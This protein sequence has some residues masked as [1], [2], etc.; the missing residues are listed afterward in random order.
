MA[1]LRNKNL[2]SPDSIRQRIKSSWD[3]T[4]LAPVGD[5]LIRLVDSTKGTDGTWNSSQSQ[6]ALHHANRLFDRLPDDTGARFIFDAIMIQSFAEAWSNSGARLSGAIVPSYG[7]EW[8]LDRQPLYP[9]PLP[10]QIHNLELLVIRGENRVDDVDLTDYAWMVHE[11]AHSFLYRNAKIAIDAMGRRL[12]IPL[13]ELQV[14]VLTDRGHAK[15]LRQPQTD[16]IVEYWQP[17]G[18]Q[19]NWSHE[20]VIDVISIA[21][22]GPAYGRVFLDHTADDST[23][24]FELTQSHP[25]LAIRCAA[26]QC[27]AEKLGWN[28]LAEML[29]ARSR[30]WGSDGFDPPSNVYRAATGSEFVVAGIDAAFDIICELRM[31]QCSQADQFDATTVV[32]NGITPKLGVEMLLAAWHASDK[33]NP[34]ELAAWTAKV[35]QNSVIPN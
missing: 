32:K 4:P 17:T 11:L 16:K 14:G 19:Y 2:L 27:A 24:P 31:P 15:T 26:L 25:P 8:Q 35:V 23:R 20:L 18:N 5:M 12:A 29:A 10:D 13:R 33:M 21:T 9:G 1:R 28:E 6:V 7:S 22:S 3:G 34:D 30:R